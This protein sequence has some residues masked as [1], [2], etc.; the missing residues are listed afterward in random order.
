MTG[1]LVTTMIGEDDKSLRDP[2]KARFRWLSKLKPGIRVEVHY[3]VGERMHT[4]MAIRR[5]LRNGC[6]ALVA[7][8]TREMFSGAYMHWGRSDYEARACYSWLHRKSAIDL[9]K[10]AAK[11]LK[12]ANAA[13]K[14]CNKF[15]V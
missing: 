9:R 8:D 13:A 7:D 6:V 2:S 11:L 1:L 12:E 10:Q 3:L 14:T 4:C 15:F 5:D